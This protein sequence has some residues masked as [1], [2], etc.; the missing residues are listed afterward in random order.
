MTLYS[1]QAGNNGSLVI[2]RGK[3]NMVKYAMKWQK[4]YVIEF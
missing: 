1:I 4:V 3:H 2:L